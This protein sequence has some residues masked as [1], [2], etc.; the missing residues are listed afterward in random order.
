MYGADPYATMPYGSTI[1]AALNL[2]GLVELSQMGLF[3]VLIA[4]ALAPVGIVSL[5][6]QALFSV[7]LTDS[8]TQ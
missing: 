5:K 4:S 2:R 8:V 3:S 1:V 7:A 6:S